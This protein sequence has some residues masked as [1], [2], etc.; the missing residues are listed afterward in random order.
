[1]FSEGE[2]AGLLDRFRQLAAC[3]GGVCVIVVQLLMV[4]LSD[5]AA[6]VSSRSGYIR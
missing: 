2:Q 3:F 6:A 1:M 5:R 4:A